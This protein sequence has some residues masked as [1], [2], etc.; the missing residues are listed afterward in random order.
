M[1]VWL[2]QIELARHGVFGEKGGATA[3]K[4]SHL[5]PLAGL[6]SARGSTTA[7]PAVLLYYGVALSRAAMIKLQ[8]PGQFMWITGQ[9]ALWPS[10]PG[11][12]KGLYDLLPHDL[13]NI[14]FPGNT[15]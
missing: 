11:T 7:A 6:Q 9:R 2:A 15:A 8:R 1:H 14:P 12:G 13:G 5:L 3:V 10:R 4:L